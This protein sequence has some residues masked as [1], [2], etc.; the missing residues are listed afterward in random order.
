M[1]AWWWPGQAA[2]AF[3]AVGALLQA[4]HTVSIVFPVVVD[5]V[6][7][8]LIDS[9]AR[10]GGNAT[11][12]MA[13]EYSIGGKWLEL[14]KQIAPGVRRAPILR[15]PIQPAGGLISYGADYIDQY[16]KAA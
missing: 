5:P 6:G 9:L 1:S 16:R 13:F 7:G 3:G 15:D 14:L 11:G 2:P 8:G 4:T 12:F 10:P